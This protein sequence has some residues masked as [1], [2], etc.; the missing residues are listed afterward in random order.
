MMVDD[1]S[2]RFGRQIGRRRRLKRRQVAHVVVDWLERAGE[3]IL[4]HLIDAAFGFAGEQG[5]ADIECLLQVG[6]A[7][8]QHRQHPGHMEPADH[9]LNFRGAQRPCKVER[10]G[11]LVR[12]HAQT[13]ARTFT[14]GPRHLRANRA[15]GSP[16]C[17][18]G[19]ISPSSGST[20]RP[21]PRS[22]RAGS[23]ATSRR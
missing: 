6:R 14:S 2:D 17:P 4:Q 16:P 22:T 13:E 5:A 20:D 10:A 11:K 19:G 21:K 12:L 7:L 8:R 15:T 9:N 1:T 18:A 23:Q 3:G